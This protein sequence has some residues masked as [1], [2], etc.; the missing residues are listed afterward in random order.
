MI[1]LNATTKKL[2]VVLSGAVTT[3][4]LD[5]FATWRDFIASPAAY[6]VGANEAVTNNTTDVDLVGAPTASHYIVIDYVSV[7]NRDTANAT[8]TIK[9]DVS[10][11]DRILWRGLLQPG[12]KVE[13]VEGTGFKVLD[14]NG[15]VLGVGTPGAD[16]VDG[17]PGSAGVGTW[18]TAVIDFG[19]FPGAADAS[20]AVT[21]QAGILTTSLVEAWLDC[22]GDSSDHTADEHML[23]ELSIHVTDIIAG[24]GFTI[25]AIHKTTEFG[26]SRWADADRRVGAGTGIN[27][28]RPS[29]NDGGD[30]IDGQWNVFWRW[31]N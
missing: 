18:G 17:A 30:M 12:Y 6:V 11:T 19:G 10:G 21:G 13:Y 31:S 24:T 14:T 20:V 2:Q 8:V 26:P 1:G 28:V 3:N 25:H 23:A 29:P 7:F 27:Q 22:R 5:C 16:G 15:A 4:Q 9:I